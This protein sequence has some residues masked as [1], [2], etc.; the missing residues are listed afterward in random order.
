MGWITKNFKALVACDRC[1]LKET[2]TFAHLTVLGIAIPTG[3]EMRIKA[4]LRRR[5]WRHLG[6]RCFCPR[7]VND[8]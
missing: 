5:G 2:F 6:S 4:T 1:G 8:K 3:K 7:C